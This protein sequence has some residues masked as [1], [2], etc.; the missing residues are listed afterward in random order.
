MVRV[1]GIGTCASR[2]PLPAAVPKPPEP[3]SPGNSPSRSSHQKGNSPQWGYNLGVAQ[4][5]LEAL[6]HRLVE[7]RWR[8]VPMCPSCGS[9]SCTQVSG[10]DCTWR[11]WRC[12]GCRKRYGVTTGTAIHATKLAPGDWTAAVDLERPDPAAIAEEVGVSRV[13]ARRIFALI[14]PVVN[15]APAGRLRHLLS[16]RRDAAPRRDP[17]L[18]D[19]LP[20]PLRSQ[21]NPLA[22]LSAGAK[23]TL[24]ALRARPFGATAAKLAALS[25]LSCSQTTRVLNQLERRGWA[26]RT[27]KSVQLG[28]KLKPVGLWSLTWSDP[29][30]R[31]LAFLRD[32]PTEPAAAAGDCVPPRFWRNFWSGTP[33]DEL[34]ISLHGLHIAETLI[35]GR[36]PTA[37]AWA[38]GALPASVL[39]QCRALRGFD[40]GTVANLLDA[41]I[42][43]RAA[44]A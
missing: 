19:P 42:S 32:R 23:A 13:T 15:L 17:W 24:N 38:L 20:T 37:R 3:P 33:G 27:V 11:R 18:V 28:Y 22:P 29:C 21:D 34:R 36:D 9:K 12:G 2:R 4:A 43:R 7:A 41:E 1:A 5:A 39:Q 35:G 16:D 14:Q 26:E 30:M 31:A 44:P 6:D 40:T 8:G 10:A 25:G